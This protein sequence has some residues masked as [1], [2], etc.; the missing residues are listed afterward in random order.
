MKTFYGF[1]SF[2]EEIDAMTAKKFGPMRSDIPKEG[3][4]ATFDFDETLTVW[5]QM[6][7]GTWRQIPNVPN[8]KQYV[9]PEVHRGYDIY[10]ITFRDP[11]LAD[12]PRFRIYEKIEQYIDEWGMNNEIKGVVYTKLQPKGNHIYRLCKEN[13]LP[14]SAHYDDDI[15]NCKDVNNHQMLRGIAINPE[16]N[17][18]VHLPY[19]GP[20]PPKSQ[21]GVIV[22]GQVSNKQAAHV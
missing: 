20:R 4:I 14:F 17:L 1:K 18:A 16:S 2:V 22:P 19:H 21:A 6:D 13:N 3:G 10:I 5:N 15:T 12:D 9:Y 8:I 7:D 11:A